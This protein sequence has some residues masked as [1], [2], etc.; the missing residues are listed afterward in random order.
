MKIRVEKNTYVYDV[1][2]EDGSMVTVTLD[3][4]AGCNVWPRG[5]KAGSS[6]LLPRQG[7]MRMLAANGTE[8]DYYGQRIVKFR[9][10]EDERPKEAPI[11][12][13]RA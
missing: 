9:G 13:R 11:F 4:G 7:G 8:I 12:Q 5:L 10:I 6:K 3:S 2:M 1:Q